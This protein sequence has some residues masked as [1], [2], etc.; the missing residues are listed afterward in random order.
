MPTVI[1]QLFRETG[2]T[3][4]IIARSV[5]QHSPYI[6]LIPRGAY[7]AGL[8]NSIVY[9]QFENNRIQRELINFQNV[10]GTTYGSTSSQCTFSGPEVGN[11]MTQKSL[12]LVNF[13]MTSKWFCA[14][15]FTTAFEFE[16]QWGNIIDNFAENTRWVLETHGR[17]EAARIAGEK[18]VLTSNI[19]RNQND[20]SSPHAFP[21]SGGNPIV[22]TSQLTQDHLSKFYM[23]IQSRGAGVQSAYGMESGRPV[24]AL[25]AGAETSDRILRNINAQRLD[26][27]YG[28]PDELL[29]PLGVDRT[30]RGFAH[31]HDL[32][33]SRYYIGQAPVNVTSI[34]RTGTTA[35]VTTAT[36]HGYATGDY[37]HIA[38]ADSTTDPQMRAYNGA[39]VITVTS[40]TTFTYTVANGPSSPATGTIT[41]RR[42]GS[43]TGANHAYIEVSPF[44]VT[45]ATLGE[46]TVFSPIYDAAPF[47][48]SLIWVK[49][50]GKFLIPPLPPR[51]GFKHNLNSYVGDFTLVPDKSNDDP[52]GLRFRYVSL[53]EMATMILR[54]ERVYSILHLRCQPTAVACT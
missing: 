40:P 45:S 17:N 22:P 25:I 33:P 13:F 1:D 11:G 36:N 18:I 51:K 5:Y 30:F 28:K 42:L 12:Q 15:D 52:Y 8:G 35:T 24:Y 7:P 37:V 32:Y 20:T 14:K 38:G 6:D 50:A 49:D 43:T 23:E 27:N 41:A 39:K 19:N 53:F 16:N 4:E 10:T 34:T 2:R 44:D 54:N 48:R 31:I 46:K 47:E 29:R 26:L 3:A 9:Q 21:T